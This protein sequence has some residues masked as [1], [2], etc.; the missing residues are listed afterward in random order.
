MKTLKLYSIAPNY[1]SVTLWEGSRMTQSRT[2]E[3]TCTPNKG[4]TRE[5]RHGV[6]AAWLFKN[7]G[8]PGPCYRAQG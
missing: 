4:L 3:H 8:I 2:C 7:F 6:I 5:Q 1:R